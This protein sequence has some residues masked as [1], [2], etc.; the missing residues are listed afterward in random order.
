MPPEKEMV[1]S[2]KTRIRTV[3]G[4]AVYK[5][6]L[7]GL[8]ERIVR[9]FKP[10]SPEIRSI[11]KRTV[12]AY[13]AGKLEP[14]G[15]R[16]LGHRC[17]QRRVHRYTYQEPHPKK[18]GLRATRSAEC[19]LAFRYLCGIYYYERD[20]DHE[21]HN[22][23]TGEPVMPWVAMCASDG[24]SVRLL[25]LMNGDGKDD[26]GSDA[27]EEMDGEPEEVEEFEEDERISEKKA[28]KKRR[29]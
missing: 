2:R 27:V 11:M 8:N 9:T 24:S 4:Q 17:A 22:W 16:E 14:F 5:D 1:D 12:E 6:V 23:E 7:V 26:L 18:P 25:A 29:G 28:K 15:G 20:G 13:L 10:P 19:E 3:W 21:T